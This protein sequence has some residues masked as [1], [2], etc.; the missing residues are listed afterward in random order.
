MMVFDLCCMAG[1]FFFLHKIS[2]LKIRHEHTTLSEHDQEFACDKYAV[3]FMLSE[4]LNYMQSEN[5]D[6][7]QA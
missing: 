1:A 5:L 4:V 2:H 7:F 6:V 3:D